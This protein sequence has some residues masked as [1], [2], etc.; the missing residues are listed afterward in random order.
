MRF[1]STFSKG[2]FIGL[3]LFCAGLDVFS[4][5]C[6]C[7]P[8][9]TC[10]A[11]SGDYTEVTFRYNGFLAINVAVSDDN[12]ILYSNFGVPNG[13]IFTAQGSLGN[14]KFK[15]QVQASGVYVYYLDLKVPGGKRK[16]TV[17]LI[18]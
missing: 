16:G 12:G 14:G 11:C 18:R 13:T 7:P 4:Q 15:G 10:G 5:A 8:I 17:T 6:N 3:L 1:S 9:A 2:F